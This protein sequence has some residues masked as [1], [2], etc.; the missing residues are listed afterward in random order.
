MYFL[1][2]FAY[3]IYHMDKYK[4]FTLISEFCIIVTSDLFKDTKDTIYFKNVVTFM[5][6]THFRMIFFCLKSFE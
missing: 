4:V 2:I 3:M 1:F 5:N 6:W